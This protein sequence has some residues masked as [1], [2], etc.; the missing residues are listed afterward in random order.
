MKPTPR[1][2][3]QANDASLCDQCVPADFARE[4]E[5][6]LAETQEKLAVANRELADLYAEIRVLTGCNP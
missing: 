6:E 1:T 2:D 4:L 3:A 5:R